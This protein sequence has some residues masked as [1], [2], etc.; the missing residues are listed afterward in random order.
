VGGLNNSGLGRDRGP[1]ELDKY[2]Q[3]RTVWMN[4]GRPS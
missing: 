4:L 2:L 3:T 1:E